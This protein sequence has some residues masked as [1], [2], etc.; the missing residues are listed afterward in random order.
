MSLL[1]TAFR[2]S[3]GTFAFSM[4]RHVVLLLEAVSVAD[5]WGL[6]GGVDVEIR[7]HTL[8][9]VQVR[10]LAVAG[11]GD[12]PLHAVLQRNF[13]L[14]CGFADALSV[15]IME[16]ISSAALTFFVILCLTPLIRARASCTTCMEV[17]QP[18]MRDR[19]GLQSSVIFAFVL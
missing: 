18:G 3:M 8:D 2:I 19:G 16:F 9:A 15:C 13:C 12:L 5:G 7:L 4:Q 1:L 14:S 6:P 17:K 10:L 11:D